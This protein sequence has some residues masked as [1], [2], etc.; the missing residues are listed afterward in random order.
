M[1]LD[2]EKEMKHVISASQDR[3]RA[4]TRI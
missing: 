3:P 1:D 4:A 2:M